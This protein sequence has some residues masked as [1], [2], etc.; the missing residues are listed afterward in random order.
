MAWA[1]RTILTLISV[2]LLLSILVMVLQ[3]R[4]Q[5]PPQLP[6]A[7]NADEAGPP[8]GNHWLKRQAERRSKQAFER[9][10]RGPLPETNQAIEEQIEMLFAPVYERIPGFL[11]WHFS[12]IGQYKELGYA[13]L[14]KLAEETE[15]RLYAGWTE[16]VATANEAVAAVMNKEM[17]TKIED[18]IHRESHTVQPGQTKTY[19]HLLEM[20]VK[21]TVERFSISAV[22][23]AVTATG[24][25]TGGAVAGAVGAKV[26]AK[27]TAA[28]AVKTLGKVSGGILAKSGA[29]ATGAAIGSFLGPI[30][31]VVGGVAGG[32]AAWLAIDGAVVNTDEYLHREDLERRI[33]ELVDE[34]KASVKSTWPTAW[35]KHKLETLG[36]VT[37][38]ELRSRE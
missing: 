26:V 24:V 18:W 34:H 15:S 8:K 19:E 7:V 9:W 35:D 14:G 27:N 23:T 25:G 16:R 20:T 5:D 30:G 32:V 6:T 4:R 33:T 22:P 2:T 31:T 13:V 10:R 38:S 3:P 1:Y 36:P 37:P 12:I 11:D 28:L 29:V 21:D 17:R